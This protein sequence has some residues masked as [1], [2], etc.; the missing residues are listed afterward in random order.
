MT[1]LQRAIV[2][3]SSALVILMAALVVRSSGNQAERVRVVDTRLAFDASA[4]CEKAKHLASRFPE[5]GMGTPGS[6]EAAEWIA[7]EMERLKLQTEFQEFDAWWAGKQV[8]AR[9]VI[10]VDKGARPETIVLIAHYD[11][12]HHAREGAMDDASGVGVLLELARVFSREKQKKTL[13]FVASDGEDWGMLG[14]RHYVSEYPNP[15]D[16]RAA[17][18]LDYVRLEIPERVYLDGTGQFGGHVPLW[19][20][21]LAEDSVAAVGGDFTSMA[22]LD[23]YLS[24]TVPLS[25]TDQGPFLRSGVPAINLGG[26]KNDSPLAKAIYHTPQDTSENLRPELFEIYG[27]ASEMMVRTLDGLAQATDNNSCYLRTGARTYVACAA[28]RTLQTLV[29]LPLLLATLFL[30]YGMRARDSLVRSALAEVASLVLFVAPW[31]LGLV[32]LYVLVRMNSIPRYELYPA[33]PLDPFLK[34]PRWQA[35][36]IVALVCAAGWVVVALVR[37]TRLFRGGG[38]FVSTKAVCLDMLLTLSV[39]ALFLNGF[40]ATLFLG[41]AALL[42]C[43]IERARKPW[44]IAA[45]VVLLAAAAA[46]FVILTIESS[47]RLMLG[48][49]VLWYYVLGAGYGLFS[50]AT[51]MIC[52]GAVTI[53]CRLF[54][55]ALTGAA[56][57][58]E[59]EKEAR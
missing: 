32:A 9:N 40:A 22:L 34:Q 25:A 50:P 12:P 24:R 30:Y 29:F 26:N 53:G 51:V 4:A 23:Q 46:P 39:I 45:N 52:L 1:D 36:A 31:A 7:H 13:V 35:L 41:P 3:L 49:Y 8:K 18:S 10:G 58:A 28:L 27:R 15:A 5:R 44:T 54:L 2:A 43:W 47:K 19:L 57:S 20:W 6:A 55:T 14:A 59:S 21:I 33:T 16:I 38:D 11:I 17:I 48:P 56:G 42:L 37:R